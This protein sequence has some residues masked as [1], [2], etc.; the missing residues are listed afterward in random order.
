LLRIVLLAIV[1]IVGVSFLPTES[2]QRSSF[3]DP[4]FERLYQRTPPVAR[5]LLW[6]GAPIGTLVEPYT[7]APGNRRLVQYFE[8]GRMELTLGQPGQG[9]TQGLLVRELATGDIQLGDDAFSHRAPAD[10]PILAP[11][12]SGGVHPGPTYADFAPVIAE[13]APDRTTVGPAALFDSWIAAGGSVTQEPAPLDVHAAAYAHQTGHNLPDV[14][15]AWFQKQPFGTLDWQDALGY[16]ISEPYWVH[17]DRGDGNGE[18]DRLVQLFERRVVVYS[19]DLPAGER[20]ALAAVGRHYFEWRYADDPSPRTGPQIVAVMPR[21]AEGPDLTLPEGY[22]VRGVE[23]DAANIVDIAV[24]ADN[25]LV[26][27]RRDG[28]LALLDPNQPET[29]SAGAIIE[30][31]AH[32]RALATIG[33]DI[34]VADDTGI[35]RYR[36]HDGD[37]ALEQVESIAV[38]VPNGLSTL[39]PGANGTLYAMGLLDS[40]TADGAAAGM[41]RISRDARGDAHIE[42]LD[43]AASGPFV[44]DARG[45]VWSID[46]AGRLLRALPQPAGGDR[47]LQSVTPAPDKLQAPVGGR[48]RELLLYRPDGA[49]GEP[50]RDLLALVADDGGRIVR[51]DPA[52][53]DSAGPSTVAD[54]IS[55]FDDPVAVAAGL[56]GALYVVDAGAGRLYVITPTG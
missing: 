34:Y 33:P 21:P 37:G 23:V 54:F 4:A 41:V 47:T 3:A 46:D 24:T 16:P 50:T 28:T 36:D 26:V 19:P 55:G 53:G 13:R 15:V 20:F 25:R 8:R 49:N 17:A 30:G 27:A 38:S 7:A 43:M 22:Q 6:G 14:F 48:F 11:S 40:G 39:V 31:L 32:P 29:A 9:V 5:A 35:H 10:I 51:V 2:T 45:F 1:V 12:A 52:A 56:D 18:R 44:I 42:L